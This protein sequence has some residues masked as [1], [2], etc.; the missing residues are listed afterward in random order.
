[1]RLEERERYVERILN[2]MGF[3]QRDTKETSYHNP[4]SNQMSSATEI[5]M[6]NPAETKHFVW[7]SREMPHLLAADKTY[8]AMQVDIKDRDREAYE[9]RPI[10]VA[11]EALCERKGERSLVGSFWVSDQTASLR[12]ASCSHK[13]LLLDA[14]LNVLT[15]G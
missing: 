3:E 8:K 6:G 14:P 13:A 10:R 1:M 7:W 9:R 2:E 12:T 5:T 15:P 4:L 11:L